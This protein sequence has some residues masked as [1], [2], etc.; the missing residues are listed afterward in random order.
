MLSARS[1]SPLQ[2]MIF[3]P[4]PS[5]LMLAAS[6]AVPVWGAP[7]RAPAD[8]PQR[9]RL[10][11]CAI[12]GLIALCEVSGHELDIEA[13]P[14]L[15]QRY[16]EEQLSM[17]QLRE[18][19]R[20]IGLEIVGVRTTWGELQDLPGPKLIHLQRPDHYVV[21]LRSDPAWCQTV[22]YGLLKLVP[23]RGVRERYS[24]HALMLKPQTEP[25]G[26]E[27]CLR[28]DTFHHTF[29]K[30]RTG[31]RVEHSFRIANEG[32]QDLFVRPAGNL[33]CGP[34]ALS[35]SKELLEPGGSA[36]VSVTCELDTAG[37]V[38][39]SAKLISSDPLEPILF[40]CLRGSV[41]AQLRVVPQQVLVLGTKG[42]SEGVLSTTVR[43]E[44]PREAH[45]QR[46]WSESGLAEIHL[47]ELQTTDSGLMS[48]AIT[49][50]PDANRFV[51]GRQD[52]LLVES[53]DPDFP[54]LSVPLQIIIAGDLLVRPA[55]LFLGFV[56]R[57]EEVRAEIAIQSARRQKFTIRSVRANGDRI[58]VGLPQR[59]QAGW[60]VAIFVQCSKSGV[61]DGS[62][63]VRT[64]VPLEEA[65]EVPVYAHVL[66][67]P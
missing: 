3:R 2:R 62:I 22:D 34:C 23:A 48:Q 33:G 29:G 17:L 67:N 45:I 31:Q 44:G 65:V 7:D 41:S 21:L 43:V 25:R 61:V 35:V 53:D 8:E 38:T 58:R 59:D 63:V 49:L 4:R 16:P 27:P 64:D 55:A 10:P 42:E 1:T 6:V 50:R 14:R 24:G 19:A 40:F 11:S 51:G 37:E 52:R 30:A 46:V 36:V 32:R 5:V 13:R 47:G 12:V 54:L 28:L 66:P 9:E 26:A 20:T 18:A 39:K 57:Q 60:R 56:Q 15:L